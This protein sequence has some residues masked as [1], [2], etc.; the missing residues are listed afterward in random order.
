MSLTARGNKW[1]WS[2][3]LGGKLY[4]RATGVPIGG[5]AEKLLAERRAREFEL[6]VLEGNFGY[7]KRAVP[8]F[9]EWWKT[10][11]RVYLPLRSPTTRRG[12]EM[13]M[14][15]HALPFFGSRRL[16]AIT[17]S[18]CIAYMHHRRAAVSALPH[19]K[20][21]RPVAEG[22]VTRESTF[23]QAVFQRAIDDGILTE[24]P[25]RRVKRAPHAVRE[26]VLLEEE[27]TRLL[28][29]LPE[30]YQRFVRFCLGT[31][32]RLDEVRKLAPEKV[33]LSRRQATV[34]GKGRK[35]RTIPLQADVVAIVEAQLAA[36]GQLWP[37]PESSIRQV[38]RVAA[39]RV[40]IPHLS[41]HTLRHTFGWRFIKSG[42]D[43]YILS[44][45]LGHADVK[46][47]ATH[48][49]HV[50]QEDLTAAIDA[51]DLGVTGA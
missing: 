37:L 22:T 45:L 8:T 48:Y 15:V 43:I 24:N 46:T 9:A 38:L 51:R 47:T 5:K 34:L 36:E 31:G 35:V 42:G 11:E 12:Q 44:K 20:T 41:P 49:A 13:I 1:F 19:A 40:G 10:Y 17:Q 2:K 32:V 21:P 7:E 25:W 27:Q 30:R 16:D 23:L 50:L 28:A 33:D 6:A 18:D 3:R 14:R 26:R 39:S 4:R 29:V